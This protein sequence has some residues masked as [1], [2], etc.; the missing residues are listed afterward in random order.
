MADVRRTSERGA[1]KL[2]AILVTAVLAFLVLV[3]VKTVPPYVAEYQL[4]DKM[5][6]TA[7]FAVVNSYS[8]DQIRDIIY[9]SIQDLDIPVKREDIQIQ[10]TRSVVRISVD[11]SVP[12]DLI[13]YRTALHFTPSAED[14]SIV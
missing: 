12:V 4:S 5:S 1:G 7:R 8:E 14:H 9:K 10:V 2:K 3:A 6:E 11:Y 13:I